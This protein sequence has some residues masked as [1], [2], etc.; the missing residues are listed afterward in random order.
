MTVIEL[1]K[2]GVV[3]PTTT[4]VVEGYFYNVD[5]GEGVQPQNHKVG[6]NGKCT[7]Y[8]GKLCPA[9]DEVKDYLEAGGARAPEPPSGYYPMLPACCPI[10]GADVQMDTSLSSKRRGVG[11]QCATGGSLHYWQRMTDALRVAREQNPWVIPPV[12]DFAGRVEYPGIR[13]EDV[14]TMAN[15]PYPFSDGYNPNL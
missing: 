10:C 12:V 11:W 9:V 13:R 3:T 8:L 14:V 2:T 15:N 5:F 6:K 7:C 1:V 4:I